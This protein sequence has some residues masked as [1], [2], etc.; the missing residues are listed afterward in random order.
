MTEPTE[1]VITH[2]ERITRLEGISEQL[3]QLLMELRR[4][5]RWMVGIQVTGFLV[6]IGITV[7]LFV[8]LKGGVR[9]KIWGCSS[10]GR[11]RALQA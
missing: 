7:S 1:R 9:L 4:D 2:A 6:I 11:A 3:S 8:A 5:F 10:A